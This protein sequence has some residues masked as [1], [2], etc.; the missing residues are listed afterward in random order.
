L[1]HSY[2]KA[3]IAL[4]QQ[5]GPRIAEAVAQL[6]QG[7]SAAAERIFQ[8]IFTRKAAEGKAMNQ[9]AAEAA[10]HLGALAFLG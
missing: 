7:N 8:D 5:H 9:Q 1:F 4:T 10:R 3:V 6:E 2:W